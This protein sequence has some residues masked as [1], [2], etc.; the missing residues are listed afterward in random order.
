MAELPPSFAGWIIDNIELGKQIGKGAISR[1]LE[2]K[3]EGTKVVIKQFGVE[4]VMPLTDKIAFNRM[5]S[6]C[7]NISRMHHP[8]IVCFLGMYLNPGSKVPS[9]IM[10]KLHCS[11]C[12]LIEKTPLAMISTGARL[13]IL[14]DASLGLRYLHS[15]IPPIIHRALSSH[16]IM[17]SEGMKGKISCLSPTRFIDPRRNQLQMRK[18]SAF[19]PSGELENVSIGK[20][21]DVFSFGCVMLHTLSHQLPTPSEPMITDPVTLEVKIQSEVEMRKSYF[22]RIHKTNLDILI[23]I[24]ESCLN[25]SPKKRISILTLCEQLRDLVEQNHV[26][27]TIVSLQEKLQKKD[28]E[29][30]SIRSDMSNLR[31]ADLNS[32]AK[33]LAM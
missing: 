26:P 1:T 18:I 9:I 21:V 31:I 32:P 25:N 11:L 8:N 6:E 15:R 27:T 22:D 19:R 33:V 24:I 14:Y 16:Y 5:L 4:S 17:V 13:S 2:A 23:P 20:E 3:W 30:K 10:E 7:D 28:R 29:I 12:S